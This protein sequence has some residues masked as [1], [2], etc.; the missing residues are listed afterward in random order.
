MNNN[1]V[2]SNSTDVSSYH[3]HH[4]HRRHFGGQAELTASLSVSPL[5]TLSKYSCLISRSSRDGRPGYMVDPPDRTMC[6]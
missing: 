1:E 2:V 6:L 5:R 3:H 4:H